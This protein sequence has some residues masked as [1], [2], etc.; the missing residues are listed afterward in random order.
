MLESFR[1]AAVAT[2]FCCAP[3]IALSADFDG[4]KPSLIRKTLINS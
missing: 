3:A 2:A 1:N 4:S